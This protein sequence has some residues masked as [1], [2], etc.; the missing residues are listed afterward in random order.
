MRG[1]QNGDSTGELFR[2]SSLNLGWS[3]CGIWWVDQWVLISWLHIEDVWCMLGF[4]IHSRL[5]HVD[6]VDWFILIEDSD[7]MI[8][9]TLHWLYLFATSTL[10]IYIDWSY[11]IA[12]HIY[13]DF[14]MIVL[15]ASHAYTPYCIS[16]DLTCW[17]SDL[18]IILIVFE[19]DVCIT[20]RLVCLILA[21][22][23]WTWV[24]YPVLCLTVWCMTILLLR[25]CVPLVC[26]S[27]TYIPLPPTLLVSVILFIPVLTIA[28]VRPSVCLLSDRAG[29]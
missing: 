16:L 5:W 2:G 17:F 3:K 23:V 9:S 4:Y 21:Y 6:C 24:I 8:S 14:A 20:I 28:S 26:V 25:D 11:C 29:D 22:L 27:R 10:L 13:S 18:Y 1:P 12:Y 7:A 15:I 19:H